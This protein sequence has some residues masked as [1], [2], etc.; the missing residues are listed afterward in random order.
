MQKII[1]AVMTGL[2]LF[3][4]VLL[5]AAT[6]EDNLKTA[7]EQTLDALKELK[8]A[9]GSNVDE[10]VYR[11][12]GSA[13][14]EYKTSGLGPDYYKKT[15]E[16]PY[17]K[18][19]IAQGIAAIAATAAAAIGTKMQDSAMQ[20]LQS[21]AADLMGSGVPEYKTLAGDLTTEAGYIGTGDS[22]S[23]NKEAEII[24]TYAQTYL[25]VD[26]NYTPTA[27]ETAALNP[28]AQFMSGFLSSVFAV[29]STA[30]IAILSNALGGIFGK[31]GSIVGS[32]VGSIISSIV[33]SLINNTPIDAKSLGS[34][35]GS[36]AAGSVMSAVTPSNNSTSG[37]SS[38]VAGT[39]TQVVGSEN[40]VDVTGSSTDKQIINNK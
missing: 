7:K 6:T 33:S 22:I 27:S 30:A 29:L 16:S 12:K 32:T 24:N 39:A 34:T 20:Q 1:C 37:S 17:T 31:V 40:K 15:A 28:F 13:Y 26:P 9:K 8:E 38:G 19:K 35:A 3:L 23:A 21:L 4:P 36:G 25:P 10:S 5:L 2:M 18:S 11:E 14:S